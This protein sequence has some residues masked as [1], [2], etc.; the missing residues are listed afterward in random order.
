ME[1]TIEQAILEDK[2]VIILGDLNFNLLQDNSSKSW[3]RTFNSLHLKQ[4]I[5]QPTR[6]TDTS[7]TLIDHVYTNVP[8]NLT[9]HTVPH[10]SISD[11]FPICITRKMNNIC[12]SGP[13]HNSISYRDTRHLDEQ[14]FLIDMENLPW[15]MIFEADDP[16]VA[17]DLFETLFQSV[18]N[19]HAPKKIRRVKRVLQPN[20]ITADILEAIKTRDK[21]KGENTEQYRHWRNKVKTLIQKAKTDFYSDTINNNQENPRQLWKNLH[22][23]SGKSKNHQTSFINDESG[24]PVV[25]PE[26]AANTFNTFFTSVFEKFQKPE[27]DRKEFNSSKLDQNISEKIP[28]NTE[29]SIPSVSASFIETQLNNLKVNKATGIDEI[30]AKFLKLA[31]PV[32]CASL[33]FILNLSIKQ[34]LYPDNLKKAKVTPIFKKGDKSDPN[35]YRPISV[36]P[37]ISSIFER[38]IS[39]SI[40]K[41]MDKYDLIYH[42][43]SGFRK[44]HSCQTA[45]TSLVDN[46]LTAINENKVVGTILL[47]LT[48]AFDLVNHKILLQKLASYKFSP[49][50]L[51]WFTSYLKNRQQQVHVSGKLSD[52][53]KVKAGVPQGSVLGPLLFILY[54]NDLPLHIDF[55]HLDLFA[56]DSTLSASDSS[57]QALINYLMADLINFD[58]WCED[59]DMTLHL[60]KTIAMFLSTKQGT[61]K[62]MS[63]PPIISL[64]DSTIQVSEQEKLLGVFIDNNLSWSTHIENTLKKC[65]TLLYL[66][67]R[68]KQYLS[69]PVRKIFF[70]AYILPH[71]DYCCTIWGNSSAD[72]MDSLIKFQKRAAR[73]ILD[74]DLET[75]SAELFAELKWLT[76]PERVKFQKAVMMFKTMNNLNP[77]YIK[78]LFKFTNEI[79]DRCLRS[80]SD[81]LLY[82]P[83]P[84]CELYR[85]SLAYSGSKIW[86]SIPQD[87]KN[88]DSVAIFKNRYL[89]WIKM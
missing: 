20:W 68:I 69:I 72:S 32:I 53:R 38:H 11:H 81:N 60:G 8:G 64:H 34:G 51:A 44:Q 85:N 56:D 6:V 58:T 86:N 37:V 63:D 75:P 36:L 14:Q 80:A 31:S 54:I 43:Q 1:N 59:N 88:S 67:G 71:L 26:I 62:I 87:V 15:F 25:D 84:N 77:P 42:H 29:F 17:L 5:D 83:K 82:I 76:F 47:D 48:K 4:I 39:N 89:D 24:N 27:N 40:T 16:N 10:Y 30:S 55:C 57:I 2:E 65:N 46:W 73:L 22:D 18:M 70:N 52:S 21:L 45:L 28:E 3:T 78:N 79:H 7:E 33:A 66:L 35:N 9:E 61:S 13:V 74:K 23:L 49:N 12:E 41:F 19:S 50:T